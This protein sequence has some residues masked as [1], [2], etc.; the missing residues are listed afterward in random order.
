EGQN[1]RYLEFDSINRKVGLIVMDVSFISVTKILP[2]L[3]PFAEPE[4][5]WVILIKPQFEVGKDKVGAGGI[6]RNTVHQKQ[7]VDTVL[8]FTKSFGFQNLGLL[9]SPIKGTQGNREF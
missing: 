1:A 4:T 6:I 7:A 5:D 9:E 8:E 2:R 3:T